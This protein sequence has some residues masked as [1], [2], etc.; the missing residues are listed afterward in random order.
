ML[1]LL[2]FISTF[3]I[4]R[5]IDINSLIGNIGGYVGLLMG[6]SIL[7]VPSLLGQFF[8]NLIKVYI[9]KSRPSVTFGAYNTA[10]RNDESG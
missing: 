2:K 5:A 9:N 1:F 6:M 8:G 7:Q 3:F 10:P 4:Q